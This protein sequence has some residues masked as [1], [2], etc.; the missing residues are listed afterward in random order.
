MIVQIK[1]IYLLFM[2]AC[3]LDLHAHLHDATPYMFALSWR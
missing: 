2:D 1:N 3:I